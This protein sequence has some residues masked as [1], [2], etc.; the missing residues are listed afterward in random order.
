ME[1]IEDLPGGAAVQP[2]PAVG[3]IRADREEER[4]HEHNEGC[5][6]GTGAGRPATFQA[7]RL[8]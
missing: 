3:I 8:S 4:E 6:Q 7:L 5:P 1:S 2:G